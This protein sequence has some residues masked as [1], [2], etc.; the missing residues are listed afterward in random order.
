MKK[1]YYLLSLSLVLASCKKYL[2]VNT[3][4]NQ[5]AN[6]EPAF[7]L[8]QALATTAST[9]NA[10]YA[11]LSQWIGYTA[12]SLS[13][14]PNSAFESFNITQSAFQPA[15]T[16]A[17]HLIYDLN[18][19]ETTSHEKG[20][21]FFEGVAKIMKAYWFQ[22]LVDMFNNIPY[23]DAAQPE[24]VQN[25]SYDDAK[26]V[27]EDLIKKIDAGIDLVKSSAT[28][29]PADAKFDIM[30]A[31]D[32]TSWIKFANTLKLRILVRQSEIP[33]RN[34]YI[35]TEI[36]RIITEGSGFLAAGEDALINPGY[37]NS[38]NKQNPL[39]AAYGFTPNGAPATVFY[40]AHQ[41]AV[42][43]FLNTNDTRIDYIYKKP[44]NGMHLGN[45]LGSSPNGNGITSETGVGVYKTA[46]APYP[47][48]L[49]A[50]SLFLQAEAVQRG[51]LSGN[52]KDLYQQAIQAS[53]NYLQV[54][55]ASNAA[56]AYYSQAGMVNVN[57]DASPDKLQ[58]I[59]MQKWAA[60]NG[61]DALEAWVEFGRTGFP[62]ITP[63]SQSPNVTR[64]QIPVRSLYPQ[65]EYDINP[66][67]VRKQGA[68]SQ[69]DSKIFWMK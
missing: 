22:D 65:I 38:L 31:G 28:I 25:P 33:G 2:D 34:T 36:T 57:W 12:R 39:Y 24:T 27:Y 43:F 18:Y 20:L 53:F 21:P 55:D 48:F 60:L 11:S 29:L 52:A 8:S 9:H 59:A 10:Y 1:L 32:K 50:T 61:F 5:P 42:D 64:N 30:W 69:F 68:I 54:P 23:T 19:V 67:N 62:K 37:E 17:Y 40:R 26:G 44:A 63:A 6:V 7:V 56:T 51:W 35:Q 47:F 58:A 49:S 4:P 16:N 13:F 45:W 46:N 15:W 66:D 41:F 3:N 14:G